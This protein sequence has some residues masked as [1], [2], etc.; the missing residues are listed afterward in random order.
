M[1]LR[2]GTTHDSYLECFSA[3]H[4]T[5]P[6]SSL[7]DMQSRGKLVLGNRIYHYV[8]CIWYEASLVLHLEGIRF[9]R[10]ADFL[11]FSLTVYLVVRSNLNKVPISRL[12][13]TIAQDSTYYFLFIF[14]SHLVV[15]MS[16]AFASVRTSSQS[17]TIPLRLA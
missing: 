5:D 6:T 14:T 7:H 3:T 16:L 15:V 10:P 12:F 9:D 4:H 17:F 11:A 1:S 8:S 13:K 2:L